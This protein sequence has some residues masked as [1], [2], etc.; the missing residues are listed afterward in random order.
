MP[1]FILSLTLVAVAADPLDG[2]ESSRQ[3]QLAAVTETGQVVISRDRGRSWH[4]IL[5]CPEGAPSEAADDVGDAPEHSCIDDRPAARIAWRDDRLYMVCDGGTLMSWHP[6]TGLHPVA[7]HA[8]PGPS[9]PVAMAGG[10]TE[11]G[12]VDR[13]GR[14]WSVDADGRAVVLA[15]SPEP[16][17]ALTTWR[18]AWVVAGVT[19]VWSGPAPWRALAAVSA[20]AV[21]GDGSGLWLAGPEGLFELR[22][23][24]LHVRAVTP[25]S[26]VAAGAGS[27]WIIDEGTLAL[28]HAPSSSSPSPIDPG[29]DHDGPAR[30]AQ[31]LHRRAHL[32]RWLPRLDLQLRWQR[33]VRGSWPPTDM[34]DA[35]E[36]DR[37][38]P[39]PRQPPDGLGPPRN[40]GFS[41]AV[42]LSWD[43][44]LAA[45]LIALGS[46]K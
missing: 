21:A 33:G 34:P 3:G 24:Q 41:I 18:G 14:L 28:A 37:P 9:Q 16:V 2:D 15:V 7:V 1:W 39:G 4:A 44:D 23:D 20:C 38:G 27:I 26:S 29:E 25:L 45:A 19:T 22:A 10:P 13:D 6:H 43:V 8:H 11:L 46:M 5:D 17:R 36:Q 32:A 30:L 40:L 31:R 12:L 42:W 35:I